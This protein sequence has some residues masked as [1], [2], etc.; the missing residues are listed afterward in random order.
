MI[1]KLAMGNYGL[2][3]WSCYALTLIVVVLCSVQASRRHRAVYSDIVRRLQR[4]EP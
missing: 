1:E 3:V 2:Y 4:K